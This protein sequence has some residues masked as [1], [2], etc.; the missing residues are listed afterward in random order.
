MALVVVM[1]VVEVVGRRSEN[2]N[3]P[4][5][6]CASRLVAATKPSDS[7][8]TAGARSAGP[9]TQRA[10]SHGGR[11]AMAGCGRTPGSRTDVG[12]RARAEC[13]PGIGMN[14]DWVAGGRV[15]QRYA[16]VGCGVWFCVMKDEGRLWWALDMP[17]TQ[18]P[19]EA[20]YYIHSSEPSMRSNPICHFL[21]HPRQTPTAARSA[22]R[23]APSSHPTCVRHGSRVY[24]EAEG[25]THAYMQPV[26]RVRRVAT[27]PHTSS[28]IV[29]RCL[30]I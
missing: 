26:K 6:V 2:E 14:C 18:R 15:A 11:T 12:V 3:P 16:G 25:T 5:R 27:A 17:T 30:E 24:T 23:C 13:V 19:G 28:G 22:Q 10:R 9:G 1:A 20:A 21:T 29:K 4:N 8:P 7:R